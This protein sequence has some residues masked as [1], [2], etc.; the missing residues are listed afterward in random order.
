MGTDT[1]LLKKMKTIVDSYVK[2]YK[3]DFEV[4][5]SIIRR[6]SADPTQHN[7]SMFWIVTEC[8]THMG[9]SDLLGENTFS[10][11]LY[12][13]YINDQDAFYYTFFIA[14]DRLILI[15]DRYYYRHEQAAGKEQN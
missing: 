3:T 10:R 5:T 11:L 2:H 1:I 13:F 14:N 4:D 7:R 15:T 8:G 6:L 12:D 9:F